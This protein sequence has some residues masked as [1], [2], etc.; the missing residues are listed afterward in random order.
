MGFLTVVCSDK[1]SPGATTLAMLLAAAHPGRPVLVEA[2]PAGGDVPARLF[3]G[4]GRPHAGTANLLTLATDSRRGSHPQM[5][6]AH[7]AITA[8]G[9]TLVPG[10]S[11]ADQQVGLLPLWPSLAAVLAA[12]ECDVIA[13]LGRICAVHPGLAAAAAAHRILLAVR[14]N[15]EQLLRVRDRVRHLL[16]LIGEDASRLVVVVICP[17][18]TAERDQRAVARV[19][20]DA[21]LSA[22]RVVWIPF[23]PNE[24]AAFY[25]GQLN[26]RGSLSRSATALAAEL[27]FG[28]GAP[29]WEAAV[30]S[31]SGAHRGAIA[32]EPAWTTS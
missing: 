9:V 31:T 13:D 30:R 11:N 18:K 28:V 19:L 8:V 3:A 25:A 7:A 15:L 26:R 14:P 20:A 6:S 2:D 23:A 4:T 16:A 24:V 27:S 21:G 10:L 1:G 17:E 12:S 5:L 32:G 29:A 22:V